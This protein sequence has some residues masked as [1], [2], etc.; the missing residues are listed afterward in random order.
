MPSSWKIIVFSNF[1]MR[2]FLDFKPGGAL[3]HI[4]ATVYKYK[5]EQGWRRFDFQVSKV[6]ACHHTLT[7]LILSFL[8]VL[9]AF[10]PL[11]CMFFL[12]LYEL[13]L[14]CEFKFDFIWVFKEN[15][16]VICMLMLTG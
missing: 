4:L 2:C 5:S 13:L 10:P 15:R 14:L 11:I 1:Q 12:N 6:W 3:C 9:H 16:L 7:N 8:F